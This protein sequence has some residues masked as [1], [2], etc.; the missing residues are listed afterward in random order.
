MKSQKKIRLNFVTFPSVFNS[1][2]VKFLIISKSEVF[3]LSR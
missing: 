3:L 1:Q 2:I